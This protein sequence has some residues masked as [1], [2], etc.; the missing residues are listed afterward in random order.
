MCSFS[1]VIPLIF[2]TFLQSIKWNQAHCGRTITLFWFCFYCCSAP[3]GWNHTFIPSFG[4][5]WWKYDILYFTHY[6]YSIL[7]TQLSPWCCLSSLQGCVSCTIKSWHDNK[8]VVCFGNGSR[9]LI[10][11]W[12]S[13]GSLIDFGSE[14]AQFVPFREES[15]VICLFLDLLSPSSY[16]NGH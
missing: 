15:T 14:R 13:S 8:Q 3:E 11:L 12:L 10:C 9:V 7:N 1:P 2:Q 16:K 6:I 4:I 5:K